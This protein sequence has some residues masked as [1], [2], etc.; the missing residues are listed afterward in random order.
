MTKSLLLKKF[1]VKLA[2]LNPAE[3]VYERTAVFA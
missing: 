1:Q 2:F 3:F